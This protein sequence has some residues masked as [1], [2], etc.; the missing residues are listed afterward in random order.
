MNPIPFI[1]P[2]DLIP[3]ILAGTARRIGTTVRDTATGR[4][5]AHIQETGLLQET[6]GRFLPT[7]GGL[8]L[9]AGDL[10]SSVAANAQL[11]QVRQMLSGLQLLT[12]G[13]LAASVAGI[14]VSAAGFALVLHRLRGLEA[15]VC[16]VRED[17]AGVSRMAQAVLARQQTR[18][19]ARQESLLERADE[20]W[21]RSDGEDVWRSLEGPLHE[22]QVFWQGLIDGAAGRPVFL[23]ADVPL[24]QAAACYESA[25]SLAAARVQCLVLIGETI[26]A[27]R[28]ATSFLDWH[29]KLLAGLSSVAIARTRSGPT[30]ARTGA[31]ESDVRVALLYRARGLVEGVTDVQLNLSSQP[32]LLTHL[33][34]ECID[35]REYLACLRQRADTPLL[36]LPVTDR[37]SPAGGG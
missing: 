21:E 28:Q 1:V 13:G 6:V 37:H 23:D 33:A 12:A 27:V 7:A 25:V 36:L 16:R 4:I 18:D 8:M 15:V 14:G 34:A 31:D 3:R 32:A 17:V 35:G 2:D 30:A 5:I 29:E 26:A 22:E 11:A 9:S 20:A 10:V 19:W 24:G